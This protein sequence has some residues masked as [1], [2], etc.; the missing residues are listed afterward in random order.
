M[1]IQTQGLRSTQHQSQEASRGSSRSAP[2]STLGFDGQ[3][4]SRRT[5]Y[6]PG[7]SR[8]RH[9]AQMVCSYSFPAI[10]GLPTTMLSEP[11][12]WCNAHSFLAKLLSS[13]GFQRV[14]DWS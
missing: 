10:G 2:Y 8:M 5:L 9:V 6:S 4:A 1:G 3:G 13:G 12:I 11:N 7:L 14:G